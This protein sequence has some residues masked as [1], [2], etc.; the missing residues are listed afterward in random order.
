MPSLPKST[1]RPWVPAPVKRAYVAHKARTP[2]YDSAEWKALRAQCLALHPQCC[3]AGCSKP[4]K[5]ADH[6]HP[7]RLGGDFWSIKNLQGMCWSCHQRKSAKE[8]NAK[9]EQP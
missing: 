4:S 1:R 6:I 5:V 7:V 8:K 2:D 3:V 9:P